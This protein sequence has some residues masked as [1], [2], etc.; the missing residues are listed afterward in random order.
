MCLQHIDVELLVSN[1]EKFFKQQNLA[2]AI[3]KCTEILKRD[4]ADNY[5]TMED[6]IKKALDTNMT[7]KLGFRLF[8]TLEEDLKEDYRCAIPTGADKL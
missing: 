4:N 8:D 6:I 1:A 5:F 7:T 2:K 3:N